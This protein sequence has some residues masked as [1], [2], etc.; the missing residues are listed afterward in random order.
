MKKRLMI[1]CRRMSLRNREYVQGESATKGYMK[2]I[3]L[4][5]AFEQSGRNANVRKQEEEIAISV[6]LVIDVTAGPHGTA[7][8][9]LRLKKAVCVP[10]GTVLATISTICS[11]QLSVTADTK[12]HATAAASCCLEVA[13]WRTLWMVDQVSLTAIGGLSAS[14]NKKLMNFLACGPGRPVVSALLA[15]VLVL[16]WQ[17]KPG[18]DFKRREQR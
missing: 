5:Q 11:K 14:R 7:A 16:C 6:V 10:G 18:T 2:H 15:I 12:S 17:Q 13:L 4:S 3:N 1:R 8:A 9:G